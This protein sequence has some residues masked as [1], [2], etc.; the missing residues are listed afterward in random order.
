MKLRERIAHASAPVTREIEGLGP[1]HIARLS[2]ATIQAA[3][4]MD[5]K[6]A[7]DRMLVAEAVREDDGTPAF[8]AAD[9]VKAIPF[10]VYK[11]L[12]EAVAEVNALAGKKD[13]ATPSID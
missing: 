6:P 3:A 5:D 1:V 13:P 10:A 7:S 12:I 2:A 4:A 8:T 9:E 11:P